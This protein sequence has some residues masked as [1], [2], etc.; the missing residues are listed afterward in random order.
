MGSI[1]TDILARL[2]GLGVEVDAQGGKFRLR[3]RERVPAD[4]L[5]EIKAHKAELLL[6]IAR[7]AI[8]HHL[9]DPH[10]SSSGGFGGSRNREPE[11]HLPEDH[12]TLNSWCPKAPETLPI[13]DP[14]GLTRVIVFAPTNPASEPIV[15][16]QVSLV[17][18]DLIVV[19]GIM[20]ERKG[21]NR[22]AVRY[23]KV[24][25]IGGIKVDVM[26]PIA[27]GALIDLE[28]RIIAEAR[29]KGFALITHEPRG[30]VAST[31]ECDSGPEV[32]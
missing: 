18:A 20:I 8:D 26:R 27:R 31:L 24:D 6:E 17:F 32:A 12:R 30:D 21:A 23:P 5:V 11:V 7:R 4:L 1:I 29:N 16:A 10:N 22:V 2:A 25:C 19:H 13:T 14:L 28:A 9:Q 3:P 15:L